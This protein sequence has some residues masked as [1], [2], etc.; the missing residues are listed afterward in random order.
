MTMTLSCCLVRDHAVDGPARTDVL[1]AVARACSPRV[2]VHDPDRVVFDASG[3]SRALGPPATIAAE[4]NALAAS[5]GVTVR[6][7]LA[8]VWTTAWILA[9]ARPGITIVPAGEDA[10][11][12]AGLSIGWLSVLPPD[13]SSLITSRGAP[14]PRELIEDDRLS[15]L[16]R[17]GLR[18][19]GEFAALPRADLHARLGDVGVAWHR[20]ACGEA[21]TP[22]VPDESPVRFVERLPLEWPIEGLEPLSFVVARLCDPLAL[23]LERADRGAVTI[24]TR[25]QLVT[26]QTHNR[27]LEVPSPIRDSRVLRTLILLDLE[28]HPPDAA[29]DAVEIEVGVVPGAIVQGALFTHAVPTA[30][31]L[32]TLVARLT[33]LVGQSRVG[34]PMLV[35]SHDDRSVGMGVFK[36]PRLTPLASRPTPHAPG[37][38]VCAIR[39]YRHPIVARVTLDHGAP[40]SV[41]PSARGVPGGRV[42]SC[43]GPWRSSGAWWALDRRGWDRDGWDVELAGGVVYRIT[44]DRVSGQW[45]VE[46]T[47]D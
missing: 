25:L 13:G 38:S 36:I 29:I 40:A 43:A 31:D 47:I 8:G 9:H 19:I 12:L 34:V 37:E 42:V 10:A 4:V 27:T 6:V 20:A 7:A 15:L 30:E 41:M 3:L 5:H 16:R 22:I 35:D 46:G 32:A 33:A 21:L 26:R 1:E 39:R 24:A 44:R 14:P 28:S 17:W 23:A 2:D 45:E 11:A 18:T